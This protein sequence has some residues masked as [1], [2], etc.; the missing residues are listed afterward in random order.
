[1]IAPGYSAFM[2]CLLLGIFVV[3]C[4]EPKSGGPSVADTADSAEGSD[5]GSPQLP[6]GVTG[7]TGEAT[8][9]AQIDG[10]AWCSGVTRITGVRDESVCVNCDFAF[11]L[12]TEITSIAGDSAC[13]LRTFQDWLPGAGEQVRLVHQP[14][15][16]YDWDWDPGYWLL[17]YT[18]VEDYTYLEPSGAVVPEGRTFDSYAGLGFDGHGVLWDD[19]GFSHT[20]GASWAMGPEGRIAAWWTDCA[21]RVPVDE[22]S[23]PLDTTTA[24]G[25]VRGGSGADRGND[26]WS[27]PVTAGDEVRV[28]VDHFV[29]ADV[30]LSLYLTRPDGCL[31]MEGAPSR[32][33]SADQPPGPIDLCPALTWIA[34]ASGEVRVAVAL[35]NDWRSGEPADY[36]LGVE[37][38]GVPVTPVQIGDDV[39]LWTWVPTATV[40][41]AITLRW[42]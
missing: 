28:S 38:D 18:V 7:L 41:S 31:V 39:A 27:F 36:V 5:T 3:S 20:P 15:S 32:R 21:D 8:W 19:E 25:E 33:C 35:E 4:D 11:D 29:W 26:V 1:M 2:A 42:E 24:T 13:D 10:D 37:V 17:Y 14:P 22:T 23:A 30:Q 12:T 9:S 6:A 40:T 16:Y 34:T